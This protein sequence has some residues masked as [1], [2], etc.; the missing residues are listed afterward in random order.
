MSASAESKDPYLVRAAT[1]P[2][3]ILT[4]DYPALSSWAKRECRE[5][6]VQSLS[7]WA[8]RECRDRDVQS[9]SS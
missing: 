2:Q 1:P 6:D 3:G 9:L 8:K 5:R 7:S 4:V